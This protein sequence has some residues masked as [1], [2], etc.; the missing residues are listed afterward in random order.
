[1][2]NRYLQQEDRS[3]DCVSS[4][5]RPALQ[6]E[7]RTPAR[8]L[9]QAQPSDAFQTTPSSPQKEFSQKRSFSAAAASQTSASAAARTAFR[10][11]AARPQS[12]SPQPQRLSGTPPQ[13]P[14]QSSA[15]PQTPPKQQP[16]PTPQT[17]FH[18][19]IVSAS[20]TVSSPRS[21]CWFWPDSSRHGPHGRSPPHPLCLRFLPSASPLRNTKALL[22]NCR[23]SPHRQRKS[24]PKRL[25]PFRRPIPHPAPHR[26]FLP[27]RN[28]KPLRPQPR[29]SP[30]HRL[31][32]LLLPVPAAPPPLHQR[33]PDRRLPQ[34]L[35][36][37]L[38][39]SRNPH[40]LRSLHRWYLSRSPRRPR[41]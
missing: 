32:R 24:L 17:S 30:V 41:A 40:R 15:R 39:L 23:S 14:R 35:L 1:M 2:A 6:T 10:A 7:E 25:Q 5:T 9:L 31:L 34:R 18:P 20:S 26:K 19:R 11:S 36:Q 22:P 33:L 4:G 21:F 13:P 3:A 29:Q 27:S 28:R 37:R 12:A 38:P 16:A 8:P